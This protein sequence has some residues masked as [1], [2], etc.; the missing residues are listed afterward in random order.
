[1]MGPLGQ[2]PVVM[3]RHGIFQV[4]W[5][6]HLLKQGGIGQVHNGLGG[7]TECGGEETHPIKVESRTATSCG[8]PLYQGMRMLSFRELAGSRNIL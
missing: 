6:H 2:F 8:S 1:M 3:D 7:S 5:W 4:V